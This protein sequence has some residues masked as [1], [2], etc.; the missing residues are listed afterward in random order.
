MIERNK[1]FDEKDCVEILNS[2]ELNVP[3]K[4]YK[5]IYD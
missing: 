4:L 2:S 5:N 1:D 3:G